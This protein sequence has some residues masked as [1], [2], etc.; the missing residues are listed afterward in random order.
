MLDNGFWVSRCSGPYKRFVVIWP[1]GGKRPTRIREDGTNAYVFM[2]EDYFD[3]VTIPVEFAENMG[4]SLRP[5]SCK[6]L[7]FRVN[8]GGF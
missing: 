6:R 4:I 1:A 3:A 8:E 2:R 5:G 7:M